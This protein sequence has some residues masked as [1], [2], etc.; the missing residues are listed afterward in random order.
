MYAHTNPHSDHARGKGWEEP[1]PTL[2]T[3]QRLSPSAP[4]SRSS[5]ANLHSLGQFLRG[6]QRTPLGCYTGPGQQWAPSGLSHGAHTTSPRASVTLSSS[7][8]SRQP[9]GWPPSGPNA[10][11]TFLAGPTRV[12]WAALCLRPPLQCFRG[13]ELPVAS[14]LRPLLLKDGWVEGTP[15]G[16]DDRAPLPWASPVLGA[17]PVLPIQAPRAPDGRYCCDPIL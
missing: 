2:V 12:Q 3:L 4:A 10:H 8:T 14:S 17:W 7:A 6:K 11:H 13:A 9:P 15:D 1:D 5:L 16:G